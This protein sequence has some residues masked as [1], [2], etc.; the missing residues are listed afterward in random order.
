M[1]GGATFDALDVRLTH[2]SL[3]PE[4]VGIYYT[5]AWNL[6]TGLVDK[7]AASGIAA[8]LATMPAADFADNDSVLYT[9]QAGATAQNSA[10]IANIFEADATNNL[11]RGKRLIYAAPYVTFRDGSTV[12]RGDTPAYSLYDIL[13]YVDNGND[14]DALQKA[15][16]FYSDWTSVLSSYN[17]KNIG[18]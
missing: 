12:V 1:D 16:A 6:G 4:N 14:A 15:N 5:G 8:S 9:E 3:R 7:V 17:F 10:L 18:K 11:S 13:R 2:V